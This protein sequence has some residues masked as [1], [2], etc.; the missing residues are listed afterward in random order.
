MVDKPTAYSNSDL[1][2]IFERI[3]N[4]LE[5]KG[6]VIYKILAYR[7]AADSLR[8]LPEDINTVRAEGRLEQIPGVG[9]AIAEKIDELLS[10]GNLGFLDRLEAEVPPTLVDLLEVPDVGP[11]KVRLFWKEAGITNLAELEAA[12]REQHLRSLSGI[13]EKSEARIL[14]G[15][16]AL[17]R[18]TDRM[19]LGTA[20]PIARHWL[21]FLRSIPEAGQVEAA[22]SL[23]R[24]RQ[25]VG[26]ID[27]V[28]ASENSQPLMDA[29]INSEE[30]LRVLGPGREQVQRRAAQ[31]RQDAAV[32]PAARALR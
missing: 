20:W 8:A 16:E 10:T 14:A 3:S 31:R 32:D 30:V 4:L 7:K 1:A 23:R 29:F 13:G 28:A 6:E 17:A 5:I 26:D 19:L 18:R 11:K 27:L 21:A 12:A 2:N 15:I 25:T 9:K 24:W 22:G